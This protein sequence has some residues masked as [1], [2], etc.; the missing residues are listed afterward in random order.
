MPRNLDNS[1]NAREKAVSTEAGKTH[2]NVHLMAPFLPYWP[3]VRHGPRTWQLKL[4]Q[5][6]ADLAPRDRVS[7]TLRHRE[8]LTTCH[9][10]HKRSMKKH[11]LRAKNIATPR[12]ITEAGLYPS[13]SDILY[14][15]GVSE[16][17][18]L[19]FTSGAKGASSTPIKDH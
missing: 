6:R 9:A 14:F 16:Q 4:N 19:G 13:R 11:A 2:K 10:M 5:Q 1:Y 15:G 17:D 8:F 7:R 18:A 3:A 12:E